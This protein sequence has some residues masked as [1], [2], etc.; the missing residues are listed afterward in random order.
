MQPLHVVHAIPGFAEPV[1]SMTHLM[2]GGI[3]LALGIVLLIRFRGQTLHRVGLG[4]F[5]FATVFDL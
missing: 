2:G 3:A 1:S 5:F 4:V